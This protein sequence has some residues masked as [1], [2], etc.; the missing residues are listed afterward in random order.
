MLRGFA[1]QRKAVVYGRR[2]VGKTRLLL[3]LLKATRG[4]YVFVPSGG[5]A[6][7]GATQ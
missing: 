1:S 4:V 6:P 5:K 3:E 2:R 7:L